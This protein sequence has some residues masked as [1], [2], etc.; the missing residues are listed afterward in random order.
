MQRKFEIP[1]MR[2]EDIAKWYEK[3]KPIV[4]NNGKPFWL[5]K[6]KQW[7]IFYTAYT[8]LDK[9]CDFSGEVS[10]SELS[11]LADVK[12]LHRYRAP[13]GY[14][15]PTISEVI[16]QIPHEMLSRVTAFEIIYSP[17]T[18]RDFEVFNDEFHSGYHVF[19]VRLYQAKN[20]INREAHPV[21]MYPNKKSVL[22][23]GMTEEEFEK[24]KALF[25]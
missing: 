14:F 18:P 20:D 11:H 24:L 8:W 17:S 21:G 25:D 3:I 4:S 13:Y 6:L 5:M 12:M 2:N 16:S 7:E 19:L 9:K 23:I 15:R 10:Y 22:P 1:K